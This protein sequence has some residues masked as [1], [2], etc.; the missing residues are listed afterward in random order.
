MQAQQ[1]IL[2]LLSLSAFLLA[3][4]QGG[5]QSSVSEFNT[6]STIRDL[7]DSVIDPNADALWESVRTEINETGVH[8]YQPETDADWLALRH[9][10]VSLIEGGN[11]LLIPGRRV[12]PE[13]AGTD[14]EIPYAYPPE[15][16][17]TALENERPVFNGFASA[18]QS[19]A[20]QLLNA[21]DARDVN[22]LDESGELLDQACEACHS[23][24]WYPPAPAN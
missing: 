7:M 16:I 13:G 14:P 12:A 10:V 8:V 21:V 6:V 20:M 4:S 11:S 19:V 17:Q 2:R 15:Q 5:A 24:F 22:A 9:N 18:F 1:Q 23:Y 3:S